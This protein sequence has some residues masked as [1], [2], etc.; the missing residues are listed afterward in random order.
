[1]NTII[2]LSTTNYFSHYQ[3]LIACKFKLVISY[4]CSAGNSS[5]AVWLDN[6]NCQNT[7]QLCLKDCQSCPIQLLVTVRTV[8]MSPSS[9]V[10]HYYNWSIRSTHA[11]KL[12]ACMHVK[13]HAQTCMYIIIIISRSINYSYAV[14]VTSRSVSTLTSTCSRSLLCKFIQ[15]LIL[16]C[17]TNLT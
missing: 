12:H 4:A 7:K 17:M 8:K 6:V 1:M 9:V 2:G 10:S 14:Y 5:V 11:S 16:L 3:N 13:L 15:L